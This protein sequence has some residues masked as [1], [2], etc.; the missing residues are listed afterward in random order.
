MLSDSQGSGNGYLRKQTT[1]IG[2][3]LQQPLLLLP[4]QMLQHLELEAL[5]RRQRAWQQYRIRTL[6]ARP[7]LQ[8]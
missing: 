2:G 5:L 8:Q 6:A 4:D 3:M 7:S 1:T